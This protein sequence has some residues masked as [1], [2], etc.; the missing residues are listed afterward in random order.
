MLV[1]PGYRQGVRIVRNDNQTLCV[2]AN[3]N[4]AW[5]LPANVPPR[6]KTYVGFKVMNGYYEFYWK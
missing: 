5:V 6:G 1:C 2:D 4:N 3:G